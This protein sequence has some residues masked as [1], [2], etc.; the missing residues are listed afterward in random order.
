MTC[1]LLKVL[2]PLIKKC[3]LSLHSVMRRG[4]TQSLMK[5]FTFQPNSV[6]RKLVRWLPPY[7]LVF[8]GPGRCTTLL[9]RPRRWTGG[10]CWTGTGILLHL[11][12]PWLGVS[13]LALY[14]VTTHLV[15]CP[16]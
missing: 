15:T 7:Q 11:F 16:D 5:G 6:T 14:L 2:T 8:P 13:T 3:P 1:S 12:R 9:S 4:K 10:R